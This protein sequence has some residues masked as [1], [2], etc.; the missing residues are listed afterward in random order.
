VNGAALSLTVKAAGLSFPEGAG[1]LSTMRVVCEYEAALPTA[2]QSGTS[3]HYADGSNAGR[4]G[5]REVTAVGNGVSVSGP[6]PPTSVSNRL[7]SYPQDLLAVPL[8]TSD[9][10][11]VASPGGSTSAAVCIRDA[12]P[13]DAT[14]GPATLGYGCS[15]TTAST[16]GTVTPGGTDQGGTG[17]SSGTGSTT[18]SQGG[19]ASAIAAAVP[20]GVGKEIADLL[21]ANDL[22][23]PIVL[24]SLVS[25]MALGAAHALTP[26]HGKTVMAAYLVGTKG[27]ARHAVGLG[28]T[29]TVSHT[30]GVLV[31]AFI[32]LAV[33]RVTPESFNHVTGIVSGLL[34]VAIGGWLFI[35]QG[36]PL[37]RRAVQARSLARAHERE[38]AS[39]TTHEHAHDLGH[40]HPPAAGH[41]HAQAPA[42]D[43]PH[44]QDHDHNHDHDHDH[45]HG[46]GHDTPGEHSHGGVRHSHPPADAP[47]TWR[48]LFALG[49]F[50]GLVPSINALIILLATVATGRAAYGLVLVIA[51][52][53]GM[54]AVLGGIGLG[55]VYA[56]RWMSRSPSSS[57]AGRLVAWAPALTS[58]VILAVGLYVTGQAVF[59]SPT[60]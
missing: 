45:E 4:I 1:G 59:G 51:F 49:L 32:V 24:I 46:H 38:H 55:L 6:V 34:V 19:Q 17:G 13:L 60:L 7:T 8:A 54:A 36:L 40:D 39:G 41:T 22:T 44:D 15:G 26:G 35:R 11:I 31:L 57:A 20:G 50:G 2:L 47:L 5:W 56:S 52:G 3:I 16:G 25:A 28:L 10:T 23:P 29:V 12:F 27:T 37:I 9:V 42:D 58:V 53:I 43:H 18:G 21:Q 48:S 33:S 30:I 14:P